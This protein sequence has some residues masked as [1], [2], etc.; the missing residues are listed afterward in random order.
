MF[1]RTD[2]DADYLRLHTQFAPESEVSKLRVIKSII[3]A[4]PK[5]EHIAKQNNLKGLI[6]MSQSQPLIQFMQIKFRFTPVAAG[7]DDYSLPFDI[8]DRKV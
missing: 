5:M 8:E 1:V 7:S 3:F 4:L 6:Y 2:Q